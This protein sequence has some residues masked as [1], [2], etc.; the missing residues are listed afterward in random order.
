MTPDLKNTVYR[1]N[2]EA[3]L[4]ENLTYMLKW[5]L[6]LREISKTLETFKKFRLE[7]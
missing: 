3:S 6:L 4:Q 1:T 2:V 7:V 5:I